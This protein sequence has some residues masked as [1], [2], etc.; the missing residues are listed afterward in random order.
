[1]SLKKLLPHQKMTLAL[2]ALTIVIVCLG[3][4]AFALTEGEK[5]GMATGLTT[6]EATLTG[7]WMKGAMLS[8]SAVGLVMSIMKQ[9]LLPLAIGMGIGLLAV[10][11]QSWVKNAF[12]A[13]IYSILG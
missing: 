1:M 2:L 4:P 5:S 7:P 9:S 3:S 8:G 13:L 6:L 10:F 11:Q 12:T